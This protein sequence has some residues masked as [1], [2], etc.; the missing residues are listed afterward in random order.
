LNTTKK[1]TWALGTIGIIIVLL[2]LTLFIL[3]GAKEGSVSNLY[4]IP[5]GTFSMFHETNVPVEQNMTDNTKLTGD[6]SVSNLYIIP[7]GT[8]TVFHETNVSAE[9]NV[10]CNV[11]GCISETGTIPDLYN[12]M[13]T[14]I[15]RN[16]GE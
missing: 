5:A 16:K 8:F 10:T 9:Q 2:I 4:I 11:S 12:Q 6:R 14:S 15:T 1:L 13:N 3:P 7:A